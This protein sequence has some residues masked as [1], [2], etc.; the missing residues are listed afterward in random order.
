MG[1][2]G[3]HIFARFG[4]F[5]GN[6]IWVSVC[7]H[8]NAVAVGTTLFY[9]VPFCF[10]LFGYIHHCWYKQIS[11]Y[12]YVCMYTYIHIE[13]H[14]QIQIRIHVRDIHVGYVRVRSCMVA[15]VQG[16]PCT[17]TSPRSRQPYSKAAN[18]GQ[19]SLMLKLRRCP[20]KG[21]LRSRN[22]ARSQCGGLSFCVC[23]KS[24]GT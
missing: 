24:T 9:P 19:S 15:R 7:T 11:M 17:P 10:G 12:R 6:V 2:A 14:L 18:V 13:I 21:A 16:P 22:H 5:V 4:E 1:S 20:L 3:A 8:H 23:G